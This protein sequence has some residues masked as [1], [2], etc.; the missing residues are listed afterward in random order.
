MKVGFIITGRMKSTRLKKKL[1]LTLLD[2]E[3]IAWMVD[4]AKLYFKDSEIVIATSRNSQDDIL[5]E[6]AAREQIKIYRGHEDDVVLRLY[7]AAKE[8]GFDYFINITA[9]CP[10]FGFDYMDR[11]FKILEEEKAD[12]LTSLDLPHGIFTYGIR[13]KAFE[14]VIEIKNTNDTEVWG[15]YFYNNPDIFKV[16]K[17]EVT[18]QEFRPDFRLTLDYKEDF[19]FFESIYTHF[20]KNTYKVTSKELIQFLDDRPE[21]V[22]IN[23]D[24]KALYTKRWEEQ[25]DSKYED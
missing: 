8:N 10:L 25:R 6:I 14:K 2:R 11:I 17:L 9:D 22:S 24:C 4:R 21:I 13:T 20:G 5:E 15:D 7:N 3:V 23:K 18:P 16:V 19:D 12:L 1:T